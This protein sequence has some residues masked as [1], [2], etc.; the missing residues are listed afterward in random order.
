MESKVYEAA[1]M[2]QKSEAGVLIVATVSGVSF[3]QEHPGGKR[4]DALQVV[5]RQQLFV[6][7]CG[8]EQQQSL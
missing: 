5:I 6:Y 3:S 1:V 8:R 4:K 2:S 7:C